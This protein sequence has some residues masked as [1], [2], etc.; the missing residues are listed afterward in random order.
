[1]TPYPYVLVLKILV[2]LLDCIC[3]QRAV[4][5]TAVFF[6]MVPLIAVYCLDPPVVQHATHNGP[7][8]ATSFPLETVLKYA[9]YPG[10]VTVGFAHA[11][12]FLY[13]DT[14]QWFGPDITCKAIRCSD[15]D[16]VDNGD[17]ERKCQTFGCR[18]SY[19]CRAGYELDG[20]QHRYCQADGSWSPR[21][22]PQC[23]RKQHSQ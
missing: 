15:P 8:E 4:T 21:L 17:V 23:L 11:K 6:Q 2:F 20:R 1:M 12:C 9:C 13:N 16:P 5:G 22:L 3:E 7:P 18:I 14:A 19:K 10:Y